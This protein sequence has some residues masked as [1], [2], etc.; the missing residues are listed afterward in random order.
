MEENQ[1]VFG[2]HL[3]ADIYGAPKEQLAN[4]EGVF[5]LLMELP[6]VVNMHMLTSPY[7]VIADPE[8]KMEWGVS[9]FVMIQE[10]HISCHTWPEK[11]YV[12]M[13]IYSCKDFD[14]NQLV[15]FLKQYWKASTVKSQ[16][17]E[18]G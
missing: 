12:S 16:V 2:K 7:V 8:K 10:S 15:A 18:R 5:R 11:G 4:Y 13:D 17:I 14:D 1:K 3:V 6:S 9:G